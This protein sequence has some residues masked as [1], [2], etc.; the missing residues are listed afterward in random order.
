VEANPRGHQPRTS[1]VEVADANWEAHFEA[2]LRFHREYGHVQV[3][4]HYPPCPRLSF[5][6]AA[7][8]TCLGQLTL[9]Q[10]RRLW[11][12]GVRFAGWENSWLTQFFKLEDGRVRYGNANDE[13]IFAEDRSLRRWRQV[14]QGGQEDM[15]PHRRR[16]LDEIDFEWG[17]SRA[18]WESHFTAAVDFKT[19][20]G[21]C[22]MPDD[23]REN[24]DLGEWLSFQWRWLK[25]PQRKER[26]LEAGI[27]LSESARLWEKRFKDW[28]DYVREFGTRSFSKNDEAHCVL[29][30]WSRL[31]RLQRRRGKLDAGRME[32][33]EAAGFVWTPQTDQWEGRFRELVQFRASHGHC[34]VGETEGRSNLAAWCWDQIRHHKMGEVSEERVARLDALGFIWNP[35][36][37]FADCMLEKM[38]AFH[39]LHGHGRVPGGRKGDYLLVQWIGRQ[40]QARKKGLLTPERI[41]ELD[42]LFE[43]EPAPPPE[44]WDRCFSE[45]EAFRKIHGHCEVGKVAGESRLAKWCN[46][47]KSQH[48]R[49]LLAPERIARLDALGF[50]WEARQ[51]VFE[52]M[53]QKLR[54]FRARHGHCRVPSSGPQA[55]PRLHQWIA[56]MRKARK[57]GVLSAARTAQLDGIIDW[58]P[59]RKGLPTRKL[60]FP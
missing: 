59:A 24:P 32:R 15:P 29:A 20:F 37:A 34:R 5:W 49:G 22:W 51:V 35:R 54:A 16:L 53:L 17:V 1:F 48:R 46:S 50:V 9:A 60:R 27:F 10:V 47:Q 30:Q 6:L 28:C 33:L 44:K 43:W 8:R 3:P 19:R 56:R 2:L 18:P 38:K 42:G 36:Q 25:D 26:M 14:Q 21:H 4:R 12:M 40:R 58:E 41:A 13:R 45:L 23:W 11:E 57:K 31:Q 7:Q 55:E 52:K 39:A